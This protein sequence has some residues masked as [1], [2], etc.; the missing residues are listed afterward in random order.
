MGGR[1]D[2]GFCIDVEIAIRQWLMAIDLYANVFALQ[3]LLKM[4]STEHT[5]YGTQVMA[6][7]AAL[8][9]NSRPRPAFAL[10]EPLVP[11]VDWFPLL[12]DC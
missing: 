8:P 6:S 12:R 7:V 3:L 11:V 1:S 10:P 5:T 2:Y 9:P 4:P